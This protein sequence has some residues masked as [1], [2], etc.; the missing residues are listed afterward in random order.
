[1]FECLEKIT[2]TIAESHL[3][4]A[5]Q[6]YKRARKKHPLNAELLRTKQQKLTAC[7]T[8]YIIACEQYQE[9][10]PNRPKVFRE[11]LIK[12]SSFERDLNQ[13]P[14][15]EPESIFSLP[16]EPLVDE[17]P[18]EIND[19]RDKNGRRRA[20][21]PEELARLAAKK[22]MQ[23]MGSIASAF[24]EKNQPIDADTW[25]N[26]GRGAGYL[27]QGQLR[28]MKNGQYR[29][30]ASDSVRAHKAQVAEA[31]T[32][33]RQLEQKQLAEEVHAR[34]SDPR[35]PTLMKPAG[36]GKE[37]E[38]QNILQ[39]L[40]MPTN[41]LTPTLVALQ[42]HLVALGKD[43]ARWNQFLAHFPEGKKLR[44]LAQ[45]NYKGQEDKDNWNNA[46][47]AEN[48]RRQG[49]GGEAFRQQAA[50][51]KYL[52]DWNERAKNLSIDAKMTATTVVA[53]FAAGE[54]VS[55]TKGS[56]DDPA[57]EAIG[58]AIYSK[59]ADAHPQN[60]VPPRG[61]VGD[62]LK[63]IADAAKDSA[64]ATITQVNAQIQQNAQN[65]ST[66]AV[67]ARAAYH[68]V[69]SKNLTQEDE[70][71][72]IQ[73]ELQRNLRLA[74]LPEADAKLAARTMHGIVVQ[75]I[76][77]KE[78][79]LKSPN[80]TVVAHAKSDIAAV[81]SV[82]SAVIIAAYQS[83]NADFIEHAN[84]IALAV[85]SAA[86][87]GNAA[88]INAIRTY[89]ET[90]NIPE[91]GQFI[92]SLSEAALTGLAIGKGES[93]RIRAKSEINMEIVQQLQAQGAN[94]PVAEGVARRL[95]ARP[96]VDEK[97]VREEL[98]DETQRVNA[99]ANRIYTTLQVDQNMPVALKRAISHRLISQYYDNHFIDSTNPN[100]DKIQVMS[101]H[102]AQVIQEYN[103][104]EEKKQGGVRYIIDHNLVARVV[105]QE[106]EQAYDAPLDPAG[107]QRVDENQ[108]PHFAPSDAVQAQIVGAGTKAYEASS[109]S[110]HAARI[111]DAS[112][113]AIEKEAGTHKVVS[114]AAQ[115]TV[116]GSNQNAV[117]QAISSA[118][119]D[120]MAASASIAAATAAAIVQARR[121][122]NLADDAIDINIAHQLGAIYQ[123]DGNIDEYR[124]NEVLPQNPAIHDAQN[125]IWQSVQTATRIQ[126][127]IE[128]GQEAGTGIAAAT[129]SIGSAVG[130]RKAL[131][132]EI[133]RQ[134]AKEYKDNGEKPIHED[135]AH[136]I[137][138]QST[139]LVKTKANAIEEKAI[140]LFQ[141]DPFNCTLA[142]SQQMGA[143]LKALY[144]RD[145]EISLTK[146]MQLINPQLQA[147][148]PAAQISRAH[149]EILATADQAAR[150]PADSKEP[151]IEPSI[152]EENALVK[153][154]MAFSKKMDPATAGMQ[155]AT[156]A[157]EL[158]GNP[159]TSAAVSALATR[160]ATQ[161]GAT[162]DLTDVGNAAAMTRAGF[163]TAKSRTLKIGAAAAAATAV[164]RYDLTLP[165]FNQLNHSE[166]GSAPGTVAKT[167]LNRMEEGKDIPDTKIIERQQQ[168][169]TA[170]HDIAQQIGT[171]AAMAARAVEGQPFPHEQ[172]IKNTISMIALR[173]VADAPVGVDGATSNRVLKACAIGS[174]VMVAA[175]KQNCSVIDAKQLALAAAHLTVVRQGS[176][177]IEKA[178]R[179]Y[180]VEHPELKL[181]EE[182][183]YEIIQV[184]RGSFAIQ[185]GIAA[186]NAAF[187]AAA[188]NNDAIA[189][190]AAAIVQEAAR[191]TGAT[192]EE[193]KAAGE[194]A[195]AAAMKL[196]LHQMPAPDADGAIKSRYNNNIQSLSALA[197]KSLVNMGRMDAAFAASSALVSA[198][199]SGNEEGMAHA[200]SQAA[201]ASQ[202]K[203]EER[204][205]A[206]RPGSITKKLK[207]GEVYDPAYLQLHRNK[208]LKERQ[209][210][211]AK[212]KRLPQLQTIDTS[213]HLSGGNNLN[214]AHADTWKISF[215]DY[216][217]D[218]PGTYTLG[219]K[220]P[221]LAK[222]L[223]ACCD[224]DGK[225]F[226]TAQTLEEAIDLFNATHR[227]QINKDECIEIDEKGGMTV[228]LEEF[229]RSEIEELLQAWIKVSQAKMKT[230]VDI[231]R[232]STKKDEPQSVRSL[233]LGNSSS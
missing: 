84:N 180:V 70:V 100:V 16:L 65:L 34:F 82:Y 46:M 149:R 71:K 124:F 56:L 92:Q 132:L 54:A 133:S 105:M 108:T 102:I 88:V 107:I 155:V 138:N 152:E 81:A 57:I 59:I 83:N 164:A 80:P 19:I 212:S 147:P 200:V 159:V 112:R 95:A 41:N 14:P 160:G 185:E 29:G 166:L 75:T 15:T 157:T 172:D 37:L 10:H 104:V 44:D 190:V 45:R 203:P 230:T 94:R 73:E 213:K 117:K 145:G 121:K 125:L 171:N 225:S 40:R 72:Q 5:I 122:F 97:A 143:A 198:L 101:R 178:I 189:R 77:R 93:A 222:Q 49:Q 150:N 18:I 187:Q 111:S 174:G 204:D 43:E 13:L 154:A 176:E 199:W 91:Q 89:V 8:K 228:T 229:G 103:R 127:G 169:Q 12:T 140:T 110:A 188:D 6:S 156:A 87:Q 23:E 39:A 168:E 66:S 119:H 184:A 202:V 106:M 220:F 217:E 30:I 151:P 211:M 120:R 197:T 216:G 136:H 50:A 126:Q 53:G 115:T 195:K 35:N 51:Y 226:L 85:S 76:Q 175:L 78:A 137:V 86:E 64:K 74:L 28:R 58:E 153:M 61:V 69:L 3:V 24:I 167:V 191:T 99:V 116:A 48:T 148:V 36:A 206:E 79:D 90:T 201:S 186:G 179:Q 224:K 139:L 7:R 165:F 232:P 52:L 218:Q 233:G 207:M 173:T 20:P 11:D 31:L 182:S 22:Q 114:S 194:E 60:A 17:N 33:S 141:Q 1:M 42:E 183:T 205:L 134:F 130:V 146:F 113:Q 144:L 38:R 32:G 209:S 196:G 129:A 221:E 170:A 109:Q 135:K 55:D 210:L 128:W 4:E 26:F 62:E 162:L 223:Q 131:A 193:I 231:S 9:K 177:G 27:Q 68:L 163:E 142:Q 123:A 208:L 214:A 2:V 96:Q 219:E 181:S 47:K 63:A 158:S 118:H 215:T 161:T 67:S 21:S 192:D 25:K 98:K 227:D